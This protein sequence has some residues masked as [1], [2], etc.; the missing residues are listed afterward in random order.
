MKAKVSEPEALKI[1]QQYRR[2][3][4]GRVCELEC[5][6]ERLTFHVWEL[7]TPGPAWRVE[8]HSGTGPETIVVSRSAGTRA[9]ALRDVG[10]AWAA[11]RG[12]P[13]FDWEKI[14]TLL[15]SVRVV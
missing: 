2:V 11:E 8:A 7:E 5:F 14:H 6:G 9:A 15:A 3:P 13:R 4:T 10:V 1:A 12:N